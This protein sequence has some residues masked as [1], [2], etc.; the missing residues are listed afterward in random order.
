MSSTLQPAIWSCDTVQWMHCFDSCQLL[1]KWISN[2]KLQRYRYG[3]LVC[4]GVGVVVVRTR[5]PYAADHDDHEKMNAWALQV[6]NVYK[7]KSSSRRFIF[8][9]TCAKTTNT[10]L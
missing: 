1:M 6:L 10:V 4:V 3:R 7:K 9:A 8:L 5:P 2:I